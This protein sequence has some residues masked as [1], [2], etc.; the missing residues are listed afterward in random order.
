MRGGWRVRGPSRVEL[1]VGRTGGGV[2]GGAGGG[3]G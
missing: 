2:G 1:G 3:A